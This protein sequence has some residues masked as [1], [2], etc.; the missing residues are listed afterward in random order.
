MRRLVLALALLG[1]W[2]AAAQYGGY[3]PPSGGVGVEVDPVYTANG[4]PASP[5]LEDWAAL[6]ACTAADEVPVCA[7]SGVYAYQDA[8]TFR[9]TIGLGG[10]ATGD[11]LGDVPVDTI[12][13]P[14]IADAAAWTNAMFSAGRVADTAAGTGF[15]ISDNGDGTIDITAGQVAIR[16]TDDSLEPLLQADIGATDDLSL[17][18]EAWNYIYVEYNAG[19]PQVVARTTYGSDFNTDVLI[20]SVYRDGTD[21][22]VNQY[23]RMTVSDTPSL[24][25]RRIRGTDRFGHES[26]GALGDGG[27]RTLTVTAGEWWDVCCPFSTAAFDSS[28]ADTFSAWYRGAGG[29]TEQTG[30]TAVSNT[31]YDANGSLGNLT[32]G[33]YGLH[34]VYVEQDGDIATLYGQGDYTAAQANAAAPPATVPPH[35]QNGHATLIGRVA[36]LQSAAE[37]AAVQS[38]FRVAFSGA[39]VSSHNDLSGL[40]G[41]QAGEYYHLTSAELTD[42]QALGTASAEDT[43]TSTGDVVQLVD[44]GG[45]PGLPAVDGSQLTGISGGGGGTTYHDAGYISSATGSYAGD[46]VMGDTSASGGTWTITAGSAMNTG[47]GVWTAPATGVYTLS[48]GCRTSTSPSD[49]ANAI[50]EADSVR[51]GAVGS[52]QST[53]TVSVALDAGDTAKFRCYHT[54]NYTEGGAGASGGLIAYFSITTVGGVAGWSVSAVDTEAATGNSY[55]GKPVYVLAFDAGACPNATT[56]TVSTGLGADY[57]D[58]VLEARI[59]ADTGGD[60]YFTG[61]YHGGSTVITARVDD[62]NGEVDIIS[63]GNFSAYDCVLWLRYTKT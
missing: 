57:F 3:T 39:L 8:S 24:V 21:L 7:A 10:L 36:V 2:P 12:G 59:V 60:V 35:M 52:W 5:V 51:Y 53:R 26:G 9:S 15:V 63:A 19:T 56:K 23:D 30:Q 20:G 50:I 25:R 61:T 31:Q 22:H 29:W 34:W 48:S 13:S 28:G 11:D 44:V 62:A 6:G 32:A 45:S 33:N 58:V 18:D 37:L 16:A 47:T 40:Q 42:V 4:Q 41:G 1:A 38:A 14:T 49:G 54:G 27:S 17:T 55:L 43:G 46:V